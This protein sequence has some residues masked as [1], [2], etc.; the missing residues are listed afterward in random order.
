MQG[1]VSKNL[2]CWRTRGT[3]LRGKEFNNCA[4]P[5]R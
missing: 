3:S 2:I 1:K 4:C 5:V